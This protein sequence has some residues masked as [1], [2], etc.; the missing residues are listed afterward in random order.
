MLGN[1]QESWLDSQL[2]SNATRWQVLG[3][4]V[5]V[6]RVDR[7]PSEEK[8][9]SM[10]QWSGYDAPRKRLL[11]KIKDTKANAVILTGIFTAIGPMN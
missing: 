5:M 3:Q 10:D 9:G 1:R 6:A 4:Q 11:Q 2:S 8:K 7:D